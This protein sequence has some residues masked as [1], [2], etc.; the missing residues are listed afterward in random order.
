VGYR[1][2]FTVRISTL[3]KF[4]SVL[5]YPLKPVAVLKIVNIVPNH[6]DTRLMLRLKRSLIPM[7]SSMLLNVQRMPV[8]QGRLF[9]WKERQYGK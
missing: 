6:P 2:R 1:P 5:C 9:L 4:S 3:E 8:A 7:R